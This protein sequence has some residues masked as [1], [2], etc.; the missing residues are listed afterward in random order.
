[1][2][3]NTRENTSIAGN[4]FGRQYAR[5]DPEELNNDSR[6]LATLLAIVRTEGIDN[7]G[8]EEPLQSIPLPWFFNKSKEK[9]SRREMS[10]ISVTNH[11]VGIGTC[12]HVA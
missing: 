11:A 7:S 4:V 6:N 3:R 1:M 8:S 5:R 2:L 10:L 9:K 12:T